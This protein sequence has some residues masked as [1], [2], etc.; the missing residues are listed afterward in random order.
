V[1]EIIFTH[2]AVSEVAVFGVPHPRWIEVVMAVVVVRPGQSLAADELQRFCK[3]RMAGFKTPKLVE[4]V[5][6]LPKNASGKVLKRDLRTRFA[7]RAK[8]LAN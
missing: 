1:E 4:V 6:A 5:D 7:D 3:E 8:A 2:P